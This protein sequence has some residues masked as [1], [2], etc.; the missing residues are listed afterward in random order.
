LLEILSSGV[1][2]SEKRRGKQHEVFERSFDVKLCRTYKF[3]NQK[4]VYIHSN[5]VSKKWNLAADPTDYIHSSAT[6]YYS[7]VHGIYTISNVNDW[8][9]E[10]W[11][12]N[13]IE[14]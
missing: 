9:H 3:V 5:P 13:G 10:K 11:G 4:L 6:F 8:I 14:N 2:A 12:I 7:G 1:I